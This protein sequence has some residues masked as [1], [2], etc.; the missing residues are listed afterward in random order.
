MDINLTQ[1]QS[2]IILVIVGI[3]AGLGIW[4]KRKELF[5]GVKEQEY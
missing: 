1:Q 4:V 5:K 2:I 3:I